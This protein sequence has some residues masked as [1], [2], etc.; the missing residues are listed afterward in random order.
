MNRLEKE[1]L[2][3]WLAV[4]QVL[5][6]ISRSNGWCGEVVAGSFWPGDAVQFAAANRRTWQETCRSGEKVDSGSR[7]TALAF[8]DQPANGGFHFLPVTPWGTE[9]VFVG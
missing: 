7:T 3:C 4:G 9:Y 8:R 6:K 2:Q 1:K 5:R